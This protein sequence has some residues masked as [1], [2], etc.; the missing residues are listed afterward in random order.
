MFKRIDQ[1][2]KEAG[3]HKVYMGVIVLMLVLIITFYIFKWD[4]V[5]YILVPLSLFQMGLLF[6][7]YFNLSKK[8][9]LEKQKKLKKNEKK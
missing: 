8:E 9:K 2:F 5:F 7:I 4:F 3:D 6:N 1:T